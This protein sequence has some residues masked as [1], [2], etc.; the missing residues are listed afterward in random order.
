MTKTKVIHGIDFK[1][2]KEYERKFLIFSG[3]EMPWEEAE[4]LIEFLTEESKEKEPAYPVLPEPYAEK[5]KEEKE[6]QEE[7]DKDK[8]KADKGKKNGKK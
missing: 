1:I 6:K 4:K 7:K 2:V 3:L 5:L 8:K